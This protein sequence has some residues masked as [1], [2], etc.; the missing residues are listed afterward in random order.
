MNY[1]RSNPPRRRRF[2]RSPLTGQ[3]VLAGRLF[4]GMVHPI[5]PYAIRGVLWYQGESNTGNANLYRTAFPLLIQ[6]WRKHWEQGD[7]PFYYYQLA[8]YRPKTDQP[9]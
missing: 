1:R 3:H 9:G 5:L 4:H 8:N 6:D 7:F 2:H